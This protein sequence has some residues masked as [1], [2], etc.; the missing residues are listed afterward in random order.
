MAAEITASSMGEAIGLGY[1]TKDIGPQ[2]MQFQAGELARRSAE[3]NA[4]KREKKADYDK[5]MDKLFTIGTSKTHRSIQG[6]FNAENDKTKKEF[7]TAMMND[8]REKALQLIYNA[9]QRSNNYADR[10]KNYDLIEEAQRAN[11]IVPEDVITSISG[12]SFKPLNENQM[13]Y[14]DALGYIFDPTTNTYISQPYDKRNTVQELMSVPIPKKEEFD[15]YKVTPKFSED[16]ARPGYYKKGSEVYVPTDEMFDNIVKQKVSDRSFVANEVNRIA[17]NN[18]K[19]YSQLAADTKADMIAKNQAKGIDVPITAEEVNRQMVINDLTLNHKD[20]WIREHTLGEDR[21]PIPAGGGSSR[22]GKKDDKFQANPTAVIGTEH[23]TK[24]M[25]NTINKSYP[26]FKDYTDKQLIEIARKPVN[27]LNT[28]E[29]KVKVLFDAYDR[30]NTSYT[31]TDYPTVQVQ[32]T[33]DNLTLSGS[34]KNVTQKVDSIYYNTDDNK[35]YATLS[36]TGSGGGAAAQVLEQQIPL[37][38]DDLKAIRNVAE[39]DKRVAAAL[40]E[41]DGNAENFGYDTIDDWIINNAKAVRGKNSS[42]PRTTSNT[43]KTG[44]NPGVKIKIPGIGGK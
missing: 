27:Q 30:K 19:K 42:S 28:K 26:D 16:K 17:N 31:Q 24:N 10:T 39:N 14:L 37:T 12:N 9:A 43:G 13:D 21:N 5:L 7:E 34:K 36:T 33:T 18:S 6:E 4:A 29:K 25:R 40:N 22:S 23:L 1:R 38:V 32:M 11:K 35:F 20:Q 41:L 3:N 2:L 44:G 15:F 8:D